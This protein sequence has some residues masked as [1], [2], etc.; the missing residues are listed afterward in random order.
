MEGS[1]MQNCG[2]GDLFIFKKITQLLNFGDKKNGQETAELSF[3]VVN[4]C[5]YGCYP[6]CCWIW[7]NFII[8]IVMVNGLYICLQ[9]QIYLYIMIIQKYCHCCYLS[10][11]CCYCLFW[12]NLIMVNGFYVMYMYIN[13]VYFKQTVGRAYPPHS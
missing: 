9:M 11:C 7:W 13:Q 8:I 4:F 5:Y 2:G 12:Q 6:Y 1:Q 10:S 3:I